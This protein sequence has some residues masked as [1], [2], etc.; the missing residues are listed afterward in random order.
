[1]AEVVD[2]AHGPVLPA[3]TRFCLGNLPCSD[4]VVAYGVRDG[5]ED[6]L[7]GAL[8]VL[9]DADLSAAA[10]DKVLDRLP[11]AHRPRYVQVVPSIALTTWHRPIW[12]DLQSK[13]VPKPGRGRRVW[14]LSDDG[15]HYEELKPSPRTAK[16]ST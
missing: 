8:T 16:K 10:L 11:V 13:G 4:L 6:V 5:D 14:R 1:V 3:G 15:A 9:P 2:T 7:V 12:R